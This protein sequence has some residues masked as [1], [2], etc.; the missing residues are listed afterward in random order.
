[1]KRSGRIHWLILIGI[2]GLVALAVL[3]FVGGTGPTVVADKFLTALSK[4]DVNT[5]ADLSDP[6]SKSK[7]QL[8]KE[9]DFVVHKAAPYYQFKWRL[10]E[11]HIQ[12]GGNDASVD[13][14]A[15]V[16]LEKGEHLA[17][18]QKFELPMARRNGAWK[19]RVAGINRLFYP[20]MPR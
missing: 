11:E 7:E 6:G 14:I 10:K 16:D 12:P 18:D 3:L 2:V 19:V 15:N 1:M 8:R 13:F 20:F 5:L 9:W 17:F 4:G